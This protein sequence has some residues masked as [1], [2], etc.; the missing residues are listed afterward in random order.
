MTRKA[1]W[2]PTP[3]A[4]DG[5]LRWL[6]G[7]PEEGGRAYEIIRSRLIALFAGRGC[8]N[9]EDLTDETINRVMRATQKE[10]FSYEGEPIRYFYGVAK[11]VHLESLR[12]KPIPEAPVHDTAE[13]E[14]EHQCLE[15]CVGELTERSRKLVI[16]YYQEQGRARF[17]QRAELASALGIPISTLRVQ[18]HRIRGL[19]RECMEQCLEENAPRL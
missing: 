13:V 7:S 11:M 9:A 16:G 17:A 4:F 2:D 15:R 18:A 19:L 14:G 3:E 5:L 8:P 12:R 1:P 6:G 10:N